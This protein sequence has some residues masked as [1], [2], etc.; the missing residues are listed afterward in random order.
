MSY[1]LKH[2]NFESLSV[3]ILNALNTALNALNNGDIDLYLCG[4][5]NPDSLCLDFSDFGLGIMSPRAYFKLF[6]SIVPTNEHTVITGHELNYMQKKFLLFMS[7]TTLGNLFSISD[8]KFGFN[9]NAYL[10]LNK[11]VKGLIDSGLYKNA[12]DHYNKVGRAEN[13]SIAM[14][15]ILYTV[16]KKLPSKSPSML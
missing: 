12:Q 3:N 10:T 1:N 13:R 8:I 9:S 5:E 7:S 16:F 11:D 4:Y 2:F 14:S 15:I 6:K